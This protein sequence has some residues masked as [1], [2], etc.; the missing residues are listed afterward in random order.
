MTPRAP[1][2]PLPALD[3]FRLTS[4]ANDDPPLHEARGA[5]VA[6]ESPSPARKETDLAVMVG[7]YS[8]I[9]A[10]TAAL[11]GLFGPGIMLLLFAFFGTTDFADGVFYFFVFV[12]LGAFVWVPLSVILAVILGIGGLALGLTTGLV[13]AIL[14]RLT[15]RFA[16]LYQFTRVV[17]AVANAAV[18]GYAAYWLYT[19]SFFMEFFEELTSGPVIIGVIGALAGFVLVLADPEKSDQPTEMTPEESEEAKRALVAPFALWGKVAGRLGRASAETVGEAIDNGLRSQYDPNHP[20]FQKKEMERMNREFE[21]E[22]R[23][24]KRGDEAFQHEMKRIEAEAF[25]QV[26]ISPLKPPK[27]KR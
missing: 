2:L 16:G 26:P 12:L 8:V 13:A 27:K 19:H 21:Q 6:T 18:F 14:F 5:E 4:F 1:N 23:Q 11:I 3:D 25:R 24:M 7:A 10:Y 20:G 17:V 9:G 15:H 22:M